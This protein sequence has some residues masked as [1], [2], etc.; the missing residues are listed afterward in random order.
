MSRDGQ[1]QLFEVGRQQR[2]ALKL[3]D[4]VEQSVEPLT[5]A[6]DSLPHRQEAGERLGG[7]RFDLL[8][9]PRERFRFESTEHAGVAP[10][11]TCAA[12]KEFADDEAIALQ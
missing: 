6:F 11:A 8:A 2:S 10:L 9:K 3:F 7:R 4:D 5:R 12:G 1:N